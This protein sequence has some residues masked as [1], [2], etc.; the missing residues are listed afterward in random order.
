MLVCSPSQVICS[1]RLAEL[2]S[3]ANRKGLTTNFSSRSL[4]NSDSGFKRGRIEFPRAPAG[5]SI[6]MLCELSTTRARR[7]SRGNDSGKSETGPH[8]QESQD[9]EESHPESKKWP[10]HWTAAPDPSLPVERQQQGQKDWNQRRNQDR[11][12]APLKTE[13]PILEVEET[14]FEKKLKEVLH[15][16]EGDS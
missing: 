1:G 5:S 9:Q 14:V 2:V 11:R 16:M 4:T 6:V 7:F 15:A 3:S 13:V 8:Q 12:G 10:A